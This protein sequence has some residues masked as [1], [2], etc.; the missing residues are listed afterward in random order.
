[1]SQS[2]ESL[3]E[4]RLSKL[5]EICDRRK[6]LLREMYHLIQKRDNL[7]SVITVEQDGE[8]NLQLFLDRFD[9]EKYPDTGHI[10]NLQEEE[11]ALP[12]T[13][14]AYSPVLGHGVVQ[15]IAN[16][17]AEESPVS[18]LPESRLA[19]KSPT[20]EELEIHELPQVEVAMD[21]DSNVADAST[22]QIEAPET[23]KR[24]PS[25]TASRESSTVL[26]TQVREAPSEE[27]FGASEPFNETVATHSP[28]PASTRPV[29]PSLPSSA[30]PSPIPQ[31]VDHSSTASVT[32]ASGTREPSFLRVSS[33]QQRSP[34]SV[35][36][37]TIRQDSVVKAEPLDDE[38]M[39][40][41]EA[42]QTPQEPEPLHKR[43]ES[44][45]APSLSL[46]QSEDHIMDIL[47]PSRP[48]SPPIGRDEDEGQQ[49][50]VGYSIPRPSIEP[51]VDFAFDFGVADGLTDVDVTPDE[52]FGPEPPY[53]LPP[54]SLLPLEFSRRGKS[55]K[56]ERKRDKERDKGETRKEE[57]APMSL[58]KWAAVLRANPVHK[59]LSRA[60]KCL[61]TRDWSVGMTE[62]RLI[63]TFERIELLKDAGRWSFRQIKKQRGVGG[64]TKTHWDYLMDEMKW[65]R[66]D[67]REERRWKLAVAYTLAHAVVEWHEA[68]TLEERLRRGICVLWKPPPPEDAEMAEMSE[69]ELADGPFRASQ[70]GDDTG[71]DSRETGTPVNDSGSDDDSD[72]EQDKE[73]RDVLNALEPGAALQDALEQ[74]EHNAQ[75]SQSQPGIHDGVALKPKMEEIEDPAALGGGS[76]SRDEN[77]M[78]VDAMKAEAPDADKPAEPESGKPVPVEESHPGLKST[79][80]N[81]I[82]GRMGD[83]DGTH[84]KPKSKVSQY[85]PLRD[86]IVHSDLDKLFIDLDDLDIVKGMSDLSTDDFNPNAPPPPADLSS[87]F[88]DLQPYSMLDV[89]PPNGQEGR[90]KSDRRGDRD[91]PNKRADDTTYSKLVPMSKFMQVKPTLVGTLQPSKHWRDGKWLHIEE[92]PLFADVDVPPARP[93]EENLCALFEGSKSGGIHPSIMPAPVR[94]GNANKR[95]SDVVWTPAEDVLLK[96][97]VE[98]YPGNWGLV[99]EAFNSS[100]VTISTDKRS[101][102]DCLERWKEKA[103]AEARSAVEDESRSATPAAAA[104]HMTTR[105][106][107]RSASQSVAAASGSSSNSS[108]QSGEPKKR[109]RH[110][111][112]HD[113]LRKAAKRREAVQKSNAAPRAKPTAVHETHGPVTKM[114]RLTPAELSRMKAEKEARDAQELLMRRRNDELA[115]QHLLRE[116]AQRS[117]GLPPNAQQPQQPAVP[118][119]P[120]AAGA[121]GVPRTSAAV[122]QAQMVQQIRSQVGISQQQQQQRIAAA[123]L[124]GA[125]TRMSPPQLTPAQA[126]HLRALAV[127]GQ[128]AV[129]G[130]PQG[131]N[132][133][134]TAQMSQA[135][136]ASAALSAAAPAL[137]AAHLSPSFTARTASSSPGLPQQSPPLPA[138]SPANAAAVARPPSVPGQGMQMNPMLHAQNV[139]QYYLQMQQR[140]MTPDQLQ[141]MVAQVQQR[142]AQQ[143]A[144]QYAAAHSQ[145]APAQQQGQGSQG[146]GYQHT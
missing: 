20:P 120:Q 23:S 50:A 6:E 5:L 53:P 10:E 47:E 122:P 106:H 145:H 2:A 73:Q 118:L 30:R 25:Q 31:L 133:Q 1:M 44:P 27:R 143:Q 111:L 28:A 66:T 36:Q 68:G 65:M 103:A 115:R 29:S 144:Q 49:R 72:D 33:P 90:K 110:T 121:N 102:W 19:T 126:A 4:E 99:A 75:A 37:P 142:Q 83:G 101:A 96:Q 76:Q 62:V 15:Q 58:T 132:G 114:Q 92:T 140:G 40:V 125:N 55:T 134:G 56:R 116:Q 119:T 32:E 131:S 129:Q 43:S 79:S 78:E 17:E 85:A 13:P 74:L 67:F 69:P 81:P 3:V 26:D 48:A 8:E 107:K 97:I 94:S 46:Q 84:G 21:V 113:T 35:P 64:L 51:E 136:S 88:P 124:A 63:R 12:V 109:I 123:A 93:V 86:H 54:L 138:A 11:V 18:P 91:D 137:S 45:G 98:K 128:A 139:A 112:M 104:L 100:R 16:G 22:Q 42:P 24:T 52:P 38:P 135:S 95:S 59:K 71:G 130:N 57:W 108:G 105:G 9:L 82:L 117:Q 141:A 77:A 14:P 7:G 80:K 41:T 61:S 70:E 87:I 60:T 39:D 34:S 146:G 89:A 127:Q